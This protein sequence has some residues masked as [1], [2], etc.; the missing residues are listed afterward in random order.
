MRIVPV[1][2]AALLVELGSTVDEA[3][4]AR[5]INLAAAIRNE[6]PEGITD[7]VP[8]YR[9]VLVAFDPDQLDR[10]ALRERLS[11][12]AVEASTELPPGRRW[13]V[14]VVYGGPF[15]VD[16]EG[17]AAHHRLDPEELIARHSRPEYRVYMVGFQPG[18]SYLGGLD[19]SI[20]R[21]RRTEPRAR[22]PAGSVSIGG[23]QAA[24]ASVEAPSGWH[25]IGRTPARMFMAER[26]PAFLLE[27]GDRVR[28]RPVEAAA[29][30]ALDARAAAGEPVIEPA[31]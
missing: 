30:E 31:P 5:V 24:I 17:L 1:A 16:L 13:I 27:P 14:P 20:A 19:P 11:G 8:T 6:A 4:N 3:L 25:L 7:I 29:W 23:V 21:S 2:D 26:E 12:L 9:S 15:G 10:E 22:T 18:F 28:F